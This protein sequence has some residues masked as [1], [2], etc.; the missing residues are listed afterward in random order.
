[1]NGRRTS[2]YGNWLFLNKDQ[3]TTVDGSHFI[4]SFSTLDAVNNSGLNVSY[5]P[6]W[7]LKSGIPEEVEM[8]APILYYT[9][10]IVSNYLLF[11]RIVN[12][13]ET[14]EIRFKRPLN[15][16]SNTN[17]NLDS[18]VANDIMYFTELWK[19]RWDTVLCAW[20]K[21]ARFSTLS[22]FKKR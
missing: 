22:I 5:M 3:D 2:K 7:L 10:S 17:S 19:I 6:P 11:K 20:M 12:W 4:K 15:I 14:I 16:F 18:S 8:P 13:P 1:M 9:N 21:R